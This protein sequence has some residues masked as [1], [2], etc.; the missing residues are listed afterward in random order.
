MNTIVFGDK[1]NV[2]GSNAAGGSLVGTIARDR[3]WRVDECLS[4]GE[5]RA[6]AAHPAS[7][8]IALSEPANAAASPAPARAIPRFPVTHRRSRR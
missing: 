5:H 6:D 2:V 3:S 1:R 8:A 4:L 7:A